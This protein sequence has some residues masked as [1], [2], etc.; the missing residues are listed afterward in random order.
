MQDTIDRLGPQKKPSLDHRKR[1][2]L[3]LDRN[4]PPISGGLHSVMWAAR[5]SQDKAAFDTSICAFCR[6]KCQLKYAGW[7]FEAARDKFEAVGHH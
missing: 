5:T 4:V 2:I 6:V 1:L 3:K 7:S